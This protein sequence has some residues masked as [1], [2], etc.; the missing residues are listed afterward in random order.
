MKPYE[1]YSATR[2]IYYSVEGIEKQNILVLCVVVSTS[3]SAN[4][5]VAVVSM[6]PR[7]RSGSAEKSAYDMLKY[8]LH[9]SG[10]A[11]AYIQSDTLQSATCKE[12]KAYKK[13]YEIE[14]IRL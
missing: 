6:T 2:T 7:L 14:W 12:Y 9:F 3:S 13:I 11:E 1:W 5:V 8:S 4:G 10:I